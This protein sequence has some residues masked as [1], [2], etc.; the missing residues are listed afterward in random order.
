MSPKMECR[1]TS[2]NAAW[3]VRRRQS[4]R[5]FTLA[6]LLV[7]MGISSILFVALASLSLY[8]GRSFA[9]MANYVD[10]DN[11]SRNA[12]DTLTTDVRQAWSLDDYSTNSL[13]LTM[14]Q[15]GTS[16]VTYLYSSTGHTLS[17]VT[18]A[19]STVLLQECDM[20]SFNMWQRNP[21]PGTFDLVAC[22]NRD[23]CKAI[24]VTWICSR[25]IFG[26]KLNTESV[27]TARIIL[28]NEGN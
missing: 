2:S 15:A 1:I 5:A 12:L 26:Q 27:Q 18:A 10:L 3:P 22:T 25:K 19:G 4:A 8:T 28:R 6:E 14:D 21:T 13:L 11:S 20:V 24:D 9:A 23:F 16:Q 7:T 17:R